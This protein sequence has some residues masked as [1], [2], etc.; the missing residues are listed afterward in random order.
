MGWGRWGL[1]YL[2]FPQIILVIRKQ[3]VLKNQS[4]DSLAIVLAANFPPAVGSLIVDPG[5]TTNYN[6]GLRRITN[7]S[8]SFVSSALYVTSS[9][10]F[11]A[12]SHRSPY[13]ARSLP[14]ALSR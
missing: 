12:H 5:Y 6:Q 2:T 8:P 7:R 11:I 3:T 9:F 10:H 13:W 1:L 4:R 14:T